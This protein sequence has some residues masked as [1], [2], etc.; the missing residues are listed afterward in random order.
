MEYSWTYY[1]NITP[2][3]IRLGSCRTPNLGGASPSGWSAQSGSV[4]TLEQ[5]CE[6]GG[7]VA[8]TDWPTALFGCCCCCCCLG[9]EHSVSSGVRNDEVDGAE[10]VVGKFAKSHFK[11]NKHKTLFLPACEDVTPCS[12]GMATDRGGNCWRTC[13]FTCCPWKLHVLSRLPLR[14]ESPGNSVSMQPEF[15]W[16]YQRL[17]VSWH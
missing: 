3:C 16:I 13:A 14:R 5:G 6:R 12:V 8:Y 2:P 9:T 17:A 11:K 1:K 7:N 15:K 4:S 10:I